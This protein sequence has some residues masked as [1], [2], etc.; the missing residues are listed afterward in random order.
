MIEKFIGTKWYKCDFHL[1]TNASNCF[2]DNNYSPE[3]FIKEVQKK[4]LNCIAI[5]DHNSGINIDDIKKAAK[6]T[7]IVVFPGVE[8][9]CTDAK[10]HIL[11]LFDTD[12]TTQHIEDFLLQKLDLSR[13]KFGKDDAHVD[14]TV[15]EIL[16]IVDK[17]D[18]IAIPAHIDEFS[19]LSLVPETIK[20]EIFEQRLVPAVQIVHNELLETNITTKRKEEYATKLNEHY[21]KKEI[22]IDNVKQWSSCA[23]YIEKTGKLTFS[24]NPNREK[25]SKHGLW[26]IGKYY[27]WIKM[28]DEPNLESLRQAFLVPD[29]RIKNIFES[30]ECPYD[31]P[32]TW[33]KCIKVNNTD[34]TDP[35]SSF[36]IEF[37][38]QMNTIIGGRGSGKS[39]VIRFIRGALNKTGDLKELPKIEEEFSDFYKRFDKRNNKGIFTENSEI[40]IEITNNGIPY[41]IKVTDIKDINQQE[42]LILKY[43]PEKKAFEKIEQEDYLSLFDIR[44]FSQKQIYEIANNPNALINIIDNSIEGLIEKKEKQSEVLS[45]YLSISSEI[46]S[47]E[48]KV[49]GK[50][51]LENEIEEIGSRIKLLKESGI[52]DLLSENQKYNRENKSIE[53]IFSEYEDSSESFDSV[54]ETISEKDID[55]GNFETTKKDSIIKIIRKLAKDRESIIEKVK[56]IKSEYLES[57]KKAKEAVK[58]SD[59]EKSRNENIENIKTKKSELGEKSIKNIDTF[60]NLLNQIEEKEKQVKQLKKYEKDIKTKEKQ[61]EEKYKEY[62]NTITEISNFRSNFLKSI[63]HSENV[64]ISVQ[65]FRDNKC[66]ESDFREIIQKDTEYPESIAHLINKL[67]TGKLPDKLKDI[68]SDLYSLRNNEKPDGYDGNFRNCIRKLNSEQFDRL[69]LL[70]PNDEITAEY[71]PQG[72]NSFKAISTAS[73]GQKTAT[74]LTFLLSFGAEPLILDQPE[75][76]LDNHLV[77][78]LIVNRLKESKETRQVI[79]VTHNANIPVNGDSEYIIAMDSESPRLNILHQGTIDEASIKKEICDVM[80]GGEDAFKLRSQR[81]EILKH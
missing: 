28:K 11:I 73:A 45:E 25:S 26:G 22:N 7:D 36:E 8:V 80:E 57:I 62:L 42:T 9:T 2:D 79:I 47:L 43:D 31:Q 6:G 50:K 74:I 76:D 15:K 44:I 71:K 21:N 19:G 29:I 17:S 63:I 61:L 77:Y 14:K 48:E 35:K 51:R 70:V 68:H 64:K 24:D 27:S 38:P 18:A 75:D 39:S 69:L 81:Y 55:E 56:N 1:H 53:N 66:Y 30:K 20:K 41:Q 72:T 23:K 37:S 59:W 40:I 33:I 10:I 46:R 67:F 52:A 60:Q 3:N 13:D 4:E 54:I 78:G 32:E 34:I 49:E 58:T 12:K 65:P 5:T 16:K